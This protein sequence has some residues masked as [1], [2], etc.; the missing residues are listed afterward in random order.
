MTWLVVQ[1]KPKQEELASEH[2]TRQGYQV[3]LPKI[4]QRK[5]VRGQWKHIIGPLF[6]RYL[7]IE[8][9]FGTDDLA[10]VRS[11]IGVINLV[12]FG[13]EIV[14][15]PD[16]VIEFLQSQQD[17]TTGARDAS[18]WPHKRGDKVDILEGPFAGLQ[19]IFEMSKDEDRAYLLIELLGRA[20]RVQLERFMLGDPL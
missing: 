12:R 13:Q 8:A 19:G 9:R 11:T 2:L 3:F 17:P 10:P 7:F 14:P 5:R 1:T 15:V 18:A 6:P 20:T 4:E 16:S